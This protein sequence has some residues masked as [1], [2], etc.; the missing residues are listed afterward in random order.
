M[1]LSNLNEYI[2]EL[3][4][5][6]SDLVYGREDVCGVTNT[7]QITIGTKANLIG[8]T[9][10]KF[11][12]LE[13]REFIF[14][15]RTSRNGERI[16]IS[17]NYL[18]KPIILTED[19]CHFRVKKECENIL[20]PEY[21]YLYFSKSEFDRYARYNSWGSA[22]E[23]F[24]WDDMCEVKLEIPEINIQKN[25]VRQ[26]QIISDRINLLEELNETLEEYLDTLYM[27]IQKNDKKKLGELTIKGKGV[28]TGKSAGESFEKNSLN[29]IPVIGASGIM[30]YK[31]TYLYDKIVISTG[32]VGTIGKVMVWGGRNW[33]T[34]NS[35]VIDTDHIANVFCLLRQYNFDEILGGSSNPK[36]TQSD[37]N[38]ILFDV[39]TENEMKTFED[40]AIE[41]IK[42]IIL[43]KAE[44]ETLV[45]LKS[46]I[47]SKL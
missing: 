46:E 39:P 38:N 25:I 7:K 34:D 22:T 33:F 42:D 14:N 11:T 40:N 32:R 31:S 26:C 36:I 15:R 17:Y 41:L 13:P 20:L 35:L 23:F 10:E 45:D 47:I 8:R 37:L 24:N 6:N 44:I 30:G 27:N 2:E 19:Y 5:P 28:M 21:L 9:F 12:I 43:R 3:N 4:R 18:G 16:S 29:T 1:A